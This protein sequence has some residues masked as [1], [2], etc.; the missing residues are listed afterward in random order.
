MDKLSSWMIDKIEFF[1][2]KCQREYRNHDYAH[3]T[4]YHYTNL[5]CL[6]KILANRTFYF[7]DFRFLNDSLEF[8]YC[9]DLTR[10]ILNELKFQNKESFMNKLKS[11]TENPSHINYYV[12]SFSEIHTNLSL[13]RYYADDGY[14]VA[15]GI[16]SEFIFEQEQLDDNPVIS[17]IKYGERSFKSALCKLV[18]KINKII[19]CNEFRK[20]DPPNQ[21]K[22][23]D[24]LESRLAVFIITLG[25]LNKH[26][27]FKEEEEIRLILTDG[28]Y[29]KKDIYPNGFF[30][31]SEKKISMNQDF[32]HW[33]INNHLKPES[34]RSQKEKRYL[35][36]SQLKKENFKE[37]WIGPKCCPQLK[38][39]LTDMLEAL[40]FDIKKI[41]IEQESSLPYK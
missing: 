40:G 28:A 19:K 35:I 3:K 6:S 11:F 24:S 21:K 34:V 14:G 37:I 8:E 22:F 15:I 16:D 17:C 13:W 33:H 9:L 20:L 23:R 31:S 39:N 5:D 7:S 41:K 27:S 4:L 18:N 36:S 25:I 12:A 29:V 10:K 1:H 38:E 2:E 30:Y 32:P 26:P